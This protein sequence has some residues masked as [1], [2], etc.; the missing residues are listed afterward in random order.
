MGVGLAVFFD[1]GDTLASPRITGGHLS[2]L[3]VYPFVPEILTRLHMTGDQESPIALGLISNTG[4]ET[5]A[6]LNRVLVESGLSN[7]VEADLCL[8]SSIDGLDKSDPAFFELARDRAALPAGRC[9]F[10]GEDAAE[11][12]VATSVGFRVSPHPLHALHLI[13]TEFAAF[14]G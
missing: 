9:L 11:R 1:I 8:F 3:K 5:A 10:V 12:A 14:H 6:L 4:N 7:F 2:A 13:D